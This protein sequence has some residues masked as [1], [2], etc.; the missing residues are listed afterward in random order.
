M[1]ILIPKSTKIIS[2][3]G[4]MGTCTRPLLQLWLSVTRI[5]AAIKYICFPFEQFIELLA[6]SGPARPQIGPVKV[7]MERE[8]S[9][10]SGPHRWGTGISTR[11]DGFKTRCTGGSWRKAQRLLC[12]NRIE[13]YSIGNWGNTL[14]ITGKACFCFCLLTN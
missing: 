13:F 14:A 12:Q 1:S 7:E 4:W 10:K 5:S 8:L 6:I 9:G 3:S 2:C 11:L